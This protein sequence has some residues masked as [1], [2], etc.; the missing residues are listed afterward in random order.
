MS[1]HLTYG[2]AANGY[3]AFKYLPY[4][5]IHEVMPYLVRRAQENSDIMGGVGVETAMIKEELWR[6]MIPWK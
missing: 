4:G 6:R 2:L 3:K 1:D 5:P